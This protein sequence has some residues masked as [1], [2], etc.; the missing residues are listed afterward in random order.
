MAD[1]IL[2]INA[3]ASSF[4]KVDGSTAIKT[5]E[6]NEIVYPSKHIAGKNC[7]VQ[8]TFCNM[9]TDKPLAVL[10]RHD[11]FLHFDFSLNS[12][13]SQIYNKTNFPQ[14]QP[15]LGVKEMQY[16]KYASVG[17]RIVRIPDGPT[18]IKFRCFTPNGVAMT[19]ADSGP[20]LL[21]IVLHIVPVE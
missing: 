10:D 17:P 12:I 9:L 2:Q 15:V 4:T 3:T 16:N 13:W 19:A 5:C 1:C 14:M 20:P 11:T 8:A 18:S 21:N 7:L 6:V